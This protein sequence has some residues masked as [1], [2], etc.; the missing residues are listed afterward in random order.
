MS[1][2]QEKAPNI[3]ESLAKLEQEFKES[4][5][6]K[7]TPQEIVN[8]IWAGFLLTGLKNKDV[9]KCT[10]LSI[11]EALFACCQFELIPNK[12][13]QCCLLP[14]KNKD[15]LELQMQPEYKGLIEVSYKTGVIESINCG[16]VDALDVF[17]FEE[18][19]T[20]YIKHR[21]NLLED[22]KNTIAAYAVVNL[23]NG[24]QII[25]VMT[26]KEIDA[27]MNRTKQV[28]AAK[29]YNNGIDQ[30]S[31]WFNHYDEQ[32]KKTV[33]KRALKLAPKSQKLSLLISHDNSIEVESVEESKANELATMLQLENQMQGVEIEMPI[34]QS[35]LVE[36]EDANN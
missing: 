10:K 3:K 6:A 35:E 31:I 18:G 15:I 4:Q 27:I 8:K 1:D 20:P 28:A 12:T 34:R 13:G 5:I 25:Q 21:R 16:A 19:S 9:F 30:S 29:K 26:K 32:A 14:Y 33:L 17:E 11:I 22:R 2:N 23:R 36:V 24:G 7:E